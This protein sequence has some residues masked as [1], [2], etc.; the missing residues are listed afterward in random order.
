MKSKIWIIVEKCTK[1]KIQQACEK[2]DKFNFP[3]KLQNVEPLNYKMSNPWISK[4]RTLELQNVEPLNY[5]MSIPWITKCR[6]LESQNVTI[7]YKLALTSQESNTKIKCVCEGGVWEFTSLEFNQHFK[8]W[9]L[10]IL[11]TKI[12]CSIF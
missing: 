1:Y 12:K 7:N 6:T 5:K 3:G 10:W 4:C 2:Y 11:K 8:D 9:V